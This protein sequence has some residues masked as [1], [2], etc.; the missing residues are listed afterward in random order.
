MNK[1]INRQQELLRKALNQKSKSLGLAAIEREVGEK[2]TD[3]GISFYVKKGNKI[4][5]DI[6]IQIKFYRSENLLGSEKLRGYNINIKLCDIKIES[7]DN[8]PDMTVEKCLQKYRHF[9]IEGQER[10]V[11]DLFKIKD[12]ATIDYCKP[13]AD[14]GN[15]DD[16]MYM[17]KLLLEVIPQFCYQV[18][19]GEF[20]YKW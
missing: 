2:S 13:L 4:V 11:D 12:I 18:N 6:G 3:Y 5:P 8:L 16:I 10:W 19:K 20:S 17:N 9:V 7:G 1:H 15:P 14:K